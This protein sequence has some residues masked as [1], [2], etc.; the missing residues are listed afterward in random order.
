[1]GIV[2]FVIALMLSAVGYVNMSVQKKLRLVLLHQGKED[3]KTLMRKVH[4]VVQLISGSVGDQN[5]KPSA[6]P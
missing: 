4:S 5:V 1:M 6:A 3:P 2:V